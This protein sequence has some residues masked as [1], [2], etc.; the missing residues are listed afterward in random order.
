M[1]EQLEHPVEPPDLR[2]DFIDVQHEQSRISIKVRKIH[3]DGP[4]TPREEWVAYR[5]LPAHAAADDVQAAIDI[6]LDDPRL[7]R[8]CAHCGEKNPVGW[9]HSDTICQ[10]CAVTHLGIVY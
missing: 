9:M 1:S 10:A 8:S 2:N 5:E 3:W 7:F 6:A 4:H